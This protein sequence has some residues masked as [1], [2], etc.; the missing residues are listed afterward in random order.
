MD[1]DRTVAAPLTVGVLDQARLLLNGLFNW[2]VTAI[3]VSPAHF[4]PVTVVDSPTRLALDVQ[5]VAESLDAQMLLV[6]RSLVVGPLLLDLRLGYGELLRMV[7][8]VVEIIR[9]DGR[10]IIVQLECAVEWKS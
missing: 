7:D 2:N 4:L 9:E 3:S 6:V 10:P 1:V 5:F 8:I